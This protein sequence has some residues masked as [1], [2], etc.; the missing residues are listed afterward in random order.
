[1]TMKS[2]SALVFGAAALLVA[3]GCAYSA[4]YRTSGVSL[5][6]Q[7]VQVGIAGV[8]CYVNRG[9]DPMIETTTDDDQVGVDVKLQIN[10][11][12]DQIAEVSEGQIRLADADIPTTEAVPPRRSKVID[13]LPG[14]TKQVRL[15]FMPAGAADCHR[16]FELELANSVELSGQPATLNPIDFEANR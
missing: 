8:R 16:N 9:S 1:M 15:A 7:G 14:E 13:V 11:S 12:S 4:P 2:Q 5:S 10:N 3:S 6:D